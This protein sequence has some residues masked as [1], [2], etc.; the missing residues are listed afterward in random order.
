LA[1]EVKSERSM[2]PRCSPSRILRACAVRFSE[3]ASSVVKIA[4]AICCAIAQ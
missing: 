3:S 4:W 2:V 1:F